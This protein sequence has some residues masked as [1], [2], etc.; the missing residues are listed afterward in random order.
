[1][2][3][4]WV[5]GWLVVAVMMGGVAGAQQKPDATSMPWMDATL[6]AEKRAE[7]VA[8]QMTLDEKIAMMHGEGMAY[9][10]KMTQAMQDLQ[11]M[12]GNGGAG[13]AMGVA[14]LGI[15]TIEMSDAA[16]G[17]RDSA[18]N[19]RYSTALPSP[20]ASA[21]S[22]DTDA[23]CAY[24]TLI[25]KELRAQ[26]YNMTLG[27]GVNLAREPRNGRTFEYMGEDP[28]LAGTMV[29]NRIKCEGAEKIISDIKH[30]ALN[31][32]EDG[33]TMVDVKI[34]ERALRESD[35]LAFEIGVKIG[36][37]KAVMCGYNGVNGEYD[38]ESKYL[39]RD[40]LKGEWGFKG[41]VVSDWN[42]THGTEKDLAAGLDIEQDMPKFYGEALKAAVQAGRVSMAE[43][44]EHV[45]RI[46]WAEFA[47]GVVDDPPKKSVVDVEAGFE[48]SRKIAEQ[49]IVLLRNE[50]ALLPLD[51]AAMKSIA[52]I[53][54]NADMGMISGGGSAQVDPPGEKD[55]KWQKKVW[56][57]TSP[58]NA[59]RSRMPAGAITYTSGADVAEAVAEAKAAD[60]A[61]VFVWQWEAEGRDLDDLSLPEGQDKLIA[62]VAAANPRT[63]VVLET[64]TVVTMPWLA[65]T[66]AVL[67]AWYAGSKG[68]EAVANVL[69]GDVNPSGKLPITFVKSEADLPRPELVKP[70]AAG[71]GGPTPGAAG[72]LTFAVNYSEGAKVGY[73][74]FEAE[75]KPV[76][77][78]FG[79]GL[80]YTTFK[81]SDLNVDGSLHLWST[82]SFRVTNTGSRTGAEVAEV[83]ASLPESANDV[84]KR[85]VG[86]QKVWLAPGESK[87]V[88]V[89]IDPK[90]ISVWDVTGKK[91]VMPS[92]QYRVMVGGSS[93]DLPLSTSM[94]FVTGG[95][96][97]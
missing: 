37:P 70:G 63:V 49:S 96:L 16:Y 90:Y 21:A 64:G 27:G 18:A 68:G 81:Y 54:T 85:L 60:V 75:K 61:V 28:V 67:E 50:K 77:F 15:P 56:F 9:G 87:V 2:Q 48:T 82:V 62:A 10:R 91:W 40:L 73:K 53:G 44:D 86:W 22:W 80:S 7:L 74:W 1:M 13:F 11:T 29:G 88:K 42:A 95:T 23:A 14:R 92:G 25:G 45:K 58:L 79:F 36:Q 52:V 26:G 6:P 5:C 47:S 35:L 84:P 19:G 43:L 76:A 59:M 65:Q 41:L 31:D 3:R 55:P 66:G 72:G 57:P 94:Q 4:R 30:Y 69:F 89:A 32:Q 33:R 78:P 20:L 83:Y 24:G 39:L 46:L 38:C 17:V 97:R 71:E 93:V 34:G 8:A 51:K 12:Y